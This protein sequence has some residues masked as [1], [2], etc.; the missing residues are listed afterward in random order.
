VFGNLVR[1]IECKEIVPLLAE[2]LPLRE[3]AAAQHA[4]GKKGHTG[5]IVLEL[6]WRNADTGFIPLPLLWATTA[7]EAASPRRPVSP[8]RHGRRLPWRDNRAMILQWR[9]NF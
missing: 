1:R 2:T 3:I 7:F 6:G 4:F 5:Q 8:S 9:P